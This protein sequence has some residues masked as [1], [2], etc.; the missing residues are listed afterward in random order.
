MALF[1]IIIFF[2]PIILISI[3]IKTESKGPVFFLSRRVGKNNKIFKMLKFRTMIVET[4]LLH[5]NDLKYSE[6]YITKL[7]SILRKYSL[8]ELPQIYNVLIGEM[9]FVGPRPA[10]ENQYELVK[11]RN[12][13]G[14]NLLTPGITGLAQI[15]GRDQI[16]FEDK[17]KYDL[18]Y[19]EKKS[20]I[21]D[22]LILIK[23]IK[24]VRK[25]EGVKH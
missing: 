21:L 13:L 4:P 20:F 24:V 3:L 7:G 10:L 23:T 14:I 6:K 9:S 1:S 18:E 12:N 11:K 5:S 8:D 16:S 22:L 17:V 19:K 15:K 25:A 2:V